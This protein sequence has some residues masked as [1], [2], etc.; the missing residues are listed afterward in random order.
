MILSKEDKVAYKKA[1][2][3]VGDEKVDEK[4]AI[5]ALD[6]KTEIENKITDAQTEEAITQL[7]GKLHSKEEY[8][9]AI[10]EVVFARFSYVDWPIGFK[11]RV[12]IRPKGIVAAFTDPFNRLYA[13]GIAPSGDVTLDFAA[14]DKLANEAENTI[15][16]FAQ[17]GGQNTL[18]L[19]G[20]SS[21][22]QV[23]SKP[24]PKRPI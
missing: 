6:V 10:G 21:I 12:E 24:L 22:R 20:A 14:I 1:S 11:W 19:G 2:D 8:A 5:E 7:K 15:N 17:Q 16:A 23:R 3:A 13:K 4:A 9:K 18:D